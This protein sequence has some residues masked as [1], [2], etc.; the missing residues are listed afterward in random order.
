MI[1]RKTDVPVESDTQG[2]SEHGAY[3]AL[4][5]SD[6]GKLTQYGA[7]VETLAPGSR[8]SERHW[9]EREDEF[10]YVLSGA[11]TIVEDDGEHVL[12]PCDAACWPAG[13]ANAHHVVN[14]TSK[15]CSYVI[16]GTRLTHDVCHY[17]DAGRVLYTE[18]ENWRLVSDDGT[19][20]KS[21]RTDRQGD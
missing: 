10:L 16:V 3:E 19:L 18:G 14:R 13:A 1:V 11:V 12:S 15:P 2:A 9:H 20:I 7:Y 21:G 6:V 8:S 5:Y 17:P 4:R